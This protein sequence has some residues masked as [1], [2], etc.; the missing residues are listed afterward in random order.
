MNGYGVLY[1]NRLGL[2]YE[3]GLKQKDGIQIQH[4]L[5]SCPTLQRHDGAKPASAGKGR[6]REPLEA[7]QLC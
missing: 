4:Y 6:Q 1:I 2:Q 7:I 5:V 3:P